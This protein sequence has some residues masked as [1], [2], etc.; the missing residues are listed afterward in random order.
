M[1][2]TA[3]GMTAL[4]AAA[5]QVAKDAE[6]RGLAKYAKRLNARGDHAAA[7][8]VLDYISAFYTETPE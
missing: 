2:Q 5:P 6:R 4:E 8:D 7:K 3:E 1:T